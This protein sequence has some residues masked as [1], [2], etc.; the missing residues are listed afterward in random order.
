MKKRNPLAVFILPIITL[1]I[2][3]LVWEVKTKNEMKSLGADIPTA[4]L[5]IIPFVNLYWL[6]KYCKGYA[7]VTKGSAAVAF[8]LLFFLGSIGM[9]VLQSGFNKLASAGPTGPDPAPASPTPPPTSPTPPATPP[10]PPVPPIPPSP[11][12]NPVPPAPPAPPQ[13]PQPPSP[14][15]TP[16]PPTPPTSPA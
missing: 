12:A 6:Y 15:P 11:P 5:I 10:A 7:Q 16:T 14:T 9:A 13:P 3:G 4:W 1:G 2:Y 8:L